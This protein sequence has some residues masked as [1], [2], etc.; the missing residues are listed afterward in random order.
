MNKHQKTVSWPMFSMNLWLAR[1]L[2][3]TSQESREFYEFMEYIGL[4]NGFHEFL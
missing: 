4:A 2:R 3:E 1:E